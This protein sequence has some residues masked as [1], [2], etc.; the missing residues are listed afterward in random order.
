MHGLLVDAVEAAAALEL[1][2]ER[3]RTLYS[4]ERW[5]ELVF[6]K[7]DAI[8]KPFWD[9]VGEPQQ[10][11]FDACVQWKWRKGVWVP[12]G[13]E[14][15]RGGQWEVLAKPEW[16][17]FTRYTTWLILQSRETLKSSIRRLDFSHDLAFYP[18]VLK[19][20]AASAY[21]GHK[22]E[23]AEEAGR[24]IRESLCASDEFVRVWGGL[25]TPETR[26]YANWGVASKFD[27]PLHPAGA[28]E[29]A[30]AFLA[31][32]ARYEGGRYKAGHFDDLVTGED[33]DSPATREEKWRSMQDRENERSRSDGTRIVQGTVFAADDA[34]N[35]L[36]D[37]R[38]T[39][40]VK[41][42][43]LRGD[44][45]K[46]WEFTALS[47]D[48]REARVEEYTEVC[49]PVFPNL[50]MLTLANTADQ[51]GKQLFAAQMLLKIEEGGNLVFDT[52][53]FVRMPLEGLEAIRTK[54]CALFLDAAIKR[55][56]NRFQG[57][58]TAVAAVEWDI[59][60]R[61]V[62]MDGD[63]RNDWSVSELFAEMARLVREY[64]PWAVFVERNDY[65]V[66]HNQWEDYAVQAGLS[67][68][69]LSELEKAGRTNKHARI[70]AME[71]KVNRGEVVLVQDVPIADAILEEAR[72]YD[73]IVG[74]AV[75]DDA[76]DMLAQTFDPAV[77]DSGY[78][79]FAGKGDARKRPRHRYMH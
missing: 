70:M 31:V 24:A 76:L 73:R 46:F 19:K 55:P 20:P 2:L 6:P 1:R 40:A 56:E 45:R 59:Y 50:D 3:E 41:M 22:L 14:L 37:R 54:A 53:R 38:G 71:P 39:I 51:Q 79:G 9:R 21:F 13:F 64:Q 44:I 5:A 60:G 10:W 58:Y 15:Y 47:W 33:R 8:S 62:V 12:A 63:Y 27:T 36:V 72:N 78:K 32:K 29:R 25:V 4:L 23:M 30:A 67:V 57:D 43:C 42:P 35:R 74:P 66:L 28:P 48:D 26:N 18:I 11:L 65:A 69:V 16:V 17:D 34:Y 77:G 68:P 52:R 49:K 75:H 61:R 7:H